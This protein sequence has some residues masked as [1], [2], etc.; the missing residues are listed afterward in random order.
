V[1]AICQ[2]LLVVAHFAL[3]IFILGLLRQ[4]PSFCICC[5]FCHA[6]LRSSFHAF[7]LRN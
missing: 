2:L 7:I 5:P 1:L 6:F 4:F 3:L